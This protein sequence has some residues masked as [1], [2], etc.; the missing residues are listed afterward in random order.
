MVN[1]RTKTCVDKAP[2]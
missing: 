1:Q 2:P